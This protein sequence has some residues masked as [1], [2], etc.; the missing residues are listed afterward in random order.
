MR[1]ADDARYFQ[2]IFEVRKLM[3]V[4]HQLT[5]RKIDIVKC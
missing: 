3:K 4:N 1:F 5:K 2:V